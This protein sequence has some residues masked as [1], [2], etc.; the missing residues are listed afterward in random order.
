MFACLN[1]VDGGMHSAEC[2][3]ESSGASVTCL[4]ILYKFSVWDKHM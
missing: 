2:S 3:C 1:F 4:D